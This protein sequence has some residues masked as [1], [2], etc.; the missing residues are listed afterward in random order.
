MIPSL[1]PLHISEQ[2]LASNL[3]TVLQRVE[4][5]AEIII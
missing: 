4:N 1:E 2:E 3:R 5:G